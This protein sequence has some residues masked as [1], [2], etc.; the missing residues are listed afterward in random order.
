M[1]NVVAVLKMSS[2]QT[3]LMY[4]YFSSGIL[5]VF[6]MWNRCLEEEYSYGFWGVNEYEDPMML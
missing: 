6:V 3:L 2:F 5:G 4:W 1:T